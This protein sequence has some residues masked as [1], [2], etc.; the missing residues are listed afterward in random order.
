M[1]G[2]YLLG[3]LGGLLTLA[4]HC[5]P[6]IPFG[7]IN[8][9]FFG[10]FMQY[11]PVGDQSLYSDIISDKTQ[12]KKKIKEIRAATSAS[13][14]AL[15]EQINTVIKLEKQMRTSDSRYLQLFQRLRKGECTVDD[16]ELLTTRVI[17]PNH[18]VKSLDTDEWKK[19]PILV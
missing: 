16:H 17:D 5:D 18:D 7:D 19:A 6:S 4:K 9:I 10:D 1:V 11:D 13:G 15:W 12:K 8:V 14:R 3:Q 2:L